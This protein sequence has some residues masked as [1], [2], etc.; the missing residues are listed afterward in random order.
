MKRLVF[1]FRDGSPPDHLFM[2]KVGTFTERQLEIIQVAVGY[3][4]ELAKKRAEQR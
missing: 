3:E 2:D 4:M 1:E